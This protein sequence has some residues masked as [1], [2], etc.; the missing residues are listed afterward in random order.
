MLCTG[1]S[2]VHY[3][4]RDQIAKFDLNT[5]T[6]MTIIHHSF[7]LPPVP[8]KHFATI[9]AKVTEA[10]HHIGDG[11]WRRW[12]TGSPGGSSWWREPTNWRFTAVQQGQ[13]S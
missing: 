4:P 11:M 3:A 2:L 1:L 5:N 9:Q 8:L 12:F 6:L 13:A 10:D 7:L